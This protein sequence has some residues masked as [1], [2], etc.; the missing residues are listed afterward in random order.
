MK[1]PF[2]HAA[3]SMAV[4]AAFSSP[5]AFAQSQAEAPSANQARAPELA[6]VVVAATRSEVPITD[7]VADVTL[8]DRAEIERSGA[9]TL[10]EVLTR[11]GG[12]MMNHNG[13]PT[14]TTSVY[15]RGAET[16]FTSV[17]IDGVRVD[18]QSTGGAPWEAVPL[19]E[20]DR[21]EILRGPAAA[22]YGSDAMAGVVQIFTREG[23]SG[24]QASAHV[25]LATHNTREVGAS[26]RGGND[27]VRYAV[28]LNAE[29]SDGYDIKLDSNPDDDGYKR[30]SFSG[31]LD[32][33]LSPAHVLGVNALVSQLDSD[34]DGFTDGQDD[35]ASH[36]LQ[37]VGADWKAT[38]SDTYKTR[39]SVTQGV[40]KYETD[41]SPYKTK[42]DI[43]SYLLRNEWAMGAATLTADLERR[44][45]RLNNASTTPE[46]TKRTQNALALGY[47]LRSGLHTL[48][49][50]VRHDNDSEFGGHN[51]GAVAYGYD[52][53]AGWQATAS[54]GTAFRAPTLFHRFSIYGS[55]D[56]KAEEARN[57]EAGVRFRQGANHFKAIAYRN[58]VKN[59]ID[60]VAGPGDC[61][62]GSGDYAGCY[63]NVG[64]ARYTGLS[65]GGGS[66]VGNVV[67]GATLDFMNPE[68]LNTGMRLPRRAKTQANFNASTDV[69]GW[70]LGG[71][72]EYVGDR[73][74]DAANTV[75]LPS[76]QLLHVSVS[77]PLGD[78]WKLRARIN[79]L[80]DKSYESVRGYVTEGR[81]LYVGLVWEMR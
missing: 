59:L 3:L 61:I 1:V 52:L 9:T 68:N 16:R 49:L 25:G 19:S 65:L 47:G 62:N 69:A 78:Q 5:F 35:V 40:D 7:V 2:S 10:A 77:K 32:W 50:N 11:S 73:Y 20:V 76:Y 4:A 67:L 41:P 21:V 72:L 14:G 6:P 44:E 81:T 26:L 34:Y 24:L 74:D 48:Q 66:R 38:W 36:D 8:V 29:R 60:Y 42:T 64:L 18:S 75:K 80:T 30:Q 55:S 23:A 33:T 13:G 46:S 28:G 43:T 70:T 51:T 71:E 63:A 54:V 17:F 57:V 15:M 53:G 79:N 27:S 12:I 31:R 45:D 39:V 37:T 58:K 56:L 22:I